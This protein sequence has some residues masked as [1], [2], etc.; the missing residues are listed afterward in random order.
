MWPEHVAGLRSK[1]ESIVGGGQI[2]DRPIDRIAHA[3]DA[4]FYRLIPQAIV[5]PQSIADVQRLFQFSQA[6]RMPMTFRTAGTSLS[7]QAI[8]DG[9]LV[10]VA[11]HFRKVEPLDSGLRVRVQPG[12]IGGFVNLVLKPFGR[13][14]GP[15]PASINACMMGG[16]LSNNSSGMCC[17][18]S[19]NSYQT[20]DS[21]TFVL[22]SGTVIDTAAPD[23]DDRFRAQEPG[24]AAGL[25]DLRQRVLANGALTARIRHKY[26]MKNTVGYSL[27]AFVDF[28]RPVDLMRHLLI[29]SEGTLAFIAEAVLRTVPDLPFKYTG[30]LLFPTIRDACAAIV[31]LGGAGAAALEVMD[32]ASLRS[33]E[34]QPGIPASIRALGPDATGLLVEFQEAHDDPAAI[35]TRAR[36]AVAG[37]V[38]CEPARF[39]H[40]AAEQ[41]ELWRIRRG[42]IP[43]VGA[44]RQR[45][46]TL[47]IEDVVFPV[48]ALA[49]AVVDLTRIFKTHRYDEAI[50][51]G[52]AKDGNLHFIIT[53]G[54][55]DRAEVDRYERMM[56]DVVELVVK[57]YDGALKA[58]H[59]TG[60]NMAPFV[61]TE[62]GPEA[63][64]IMKRLK[65][66]VDP[67]GLL[68]P[69]V[70][71]NSDPRAHVSDLK[72]M[73]V[74]EDEVDKCIECG[75][76][77]SHCPSR[78]LTLTPRQRIVVRREIERLQDAGE[79]NGRLAALRADFQYEALDT[80]A[81]DGL[82]ALACPVSI[83]TGQLTK[84]FRAA[85][86]SAASRHI[87]AWTARHFATTERC[88]RGALQ[89]G[90]AGR[91]LLGSGTMAKATRAVR[92]LLGD[93]VP[94]WVEPMPRPAARL[95]RTSA[96]AAAGIYFPSCVT[97]TMGALPGEPD[98]MTVADAFVTVAARAGAPLHVPGD[99]RGRCCG[100]PY[101]SKGFVA[102]HAT[103][104]NATV[105]RMWEWTRHG[106]LPVVIDTSPCTYNLRSGHD[107]TAENAERLSKM[108]VLDGVEFF[109]DVV[110][111]RLE[112]VR[113]PGS[114]TL[115]PVCSLLKLGLAPRLTRIAKAC[116]EEVSVPLSAGCCGFAGDRGWLVP[117]LTASATKWEAEEARAVGAHAH[118]SSSRTCEI[119]LTRST[120][121]IYRS[122]IFLLERAS[123]ERA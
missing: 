31:P 28:E 76:C 122:F 27:N 50:I 119:G 88:V 61:E 43:S 36:E 29:G 112:I 90:Q 73:P 104:I 37:L 17:G 78:D 67:H 40:D 42:M 23:A 118:Y 5:R 24:I 55:G 92:R 116:S 110:L 1:L 113:A 52:H 16:I 54:F 70:I 115:H 79:R 91:A 69:G 62:W 77:E 30:L 86:H 35:E 51:F 57:R 97:R 99:V 11:Y 71:L 47:L 89:A 6:E 93:Q 108:R 85:D 109:A 20:L 49:D 60:R 107:L 33:V 9:L 58:E 98:E 53:Q 45:G 34:A 101:S 84:R 120:G 26:R 100:V 18:V 72:G 81:T 32:R 19:Q 38:L 56:D 3:S 65:A 15:D 83:D 80:C 102:A 82:C 68:N 103:A 117:E 111:P 22:P 13:K 64:D 8:T 7:G 121:A 21:L 4:S 75:F 74:V 2:L 123:R 66:L 96:D 105:A 12:V 94:L 10:D 46:T 87:A 48:P 59:G 95:P 114:V 41:A 106:V 39:T 14:I 44:L 63:Y 25:L